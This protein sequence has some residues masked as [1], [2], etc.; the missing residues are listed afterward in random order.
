MILRWGSREDSCDSYTG[1]LLKLHRA[2]EIKICVETVQKSVV[3]YFIHV[4]V[5]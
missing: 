4:T 1:S 2:A 5:S 3:E